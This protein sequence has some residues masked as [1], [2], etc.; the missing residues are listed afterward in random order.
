MPPL[1]NASV[2]ERFTPDSLNG[3][4]DVGSFSGSLEVP[5]ADSNS[6]PLNYDALIGENNIAPPTGRFKER[7]RALDGSND[8]PEAVEAPKI[9]PETSRIMHHLARLS[10]S[11][12]VEDIEKFALVYQELQPEEKKVFEA[13]RNQVITDTIMAKEA[14]ATPQRDEQLSPET[15]S[16]LLPSRPNQID[17]GLLDRL[18]ASLLLAKS[19]AFQSFY[20]RLTNE[21]QVAV[22]NQIYKDYQEAAGEFGGAALNAVGVQ[23][24]NNKWRSMRPGAKKASFASV[25]SRYNTMSDRAS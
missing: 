17:R 9:T 3:S 10:L 25:V 11:N 15:E 18:P 24:P 13:Y 1:G 8:Q 6:L 19:D 4:P 14:Q 21:E 20:Q 12:E 23:E 7:I 16:K 2:K 22:D 5:L